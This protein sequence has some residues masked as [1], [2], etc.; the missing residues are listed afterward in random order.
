MKTLFCWEMLGIL[1]KP[2]DFNYYWFNDLTQAPNA[3]VMSDR[4]RVFFSSR[5]NISKGKY[6]SYSSFFD[7][8]LNDPTNIIAINNKPILDLGKTGAFDEFGIY[9]FSVIEFKSKYIAVY[10]GW[11]RL[12]SVPFDVQLGLAVSNDAVNFDKIGIGP[13]LAKSL[14]EPFIIASPKLFLKEDLIYLFYIAGNKWVKSNTK[15]E[16]IYK[17]RLAT[18]TDGVNWNRLEKNIISDSIGINECQAAPEVI[19]IYDEYYMFFSY[20]DYHDY[21]TSKDHSYKIGLAKSKDLLNWERCDDLLSLNVE[22]I[23]FDETSKSYAST[24]ILDN[25]LYMLYTGNGI[26]RT[27]IGLMRTNLAK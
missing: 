18:S 27:G 13:I 17:I 11:T 26:G 25:Y 6:I 20:R 7:L 15:W 10:G 24:F 5:S 4:I 16:P 23:G 22:T 21:L 9:P 12:R 19:K 8:S 2:S 1:I 14:N 3:I